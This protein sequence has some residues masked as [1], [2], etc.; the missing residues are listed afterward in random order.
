MAA[1]SG[2]RTAKRADICRHCGRDPGSPPVV[3]VAGS[4]DPERGPAPLPRFRH[5]FTPSSPALLKFT[6]MAVDIR[7]HTN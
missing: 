6:P 4:R 3:C 2:P 5:E 1:S 7:S